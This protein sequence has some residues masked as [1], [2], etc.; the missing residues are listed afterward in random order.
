MYPSGISDKGKKLI[1]FYKGA[2][3]EGLTRTQAYFK[4]RALKLDTYA[5]TSM[6]RDMRVIWEAAEVAEPMKFTP[7]KYLVGEGHYKESSIKMTQRYATVMK[8]SYYDEDEEQ[9]ME[10]HITVRH[11]SLLPPDELKKDAQIAYEK[12]ESP[13]KEITIMP[14]AGYYWFKKR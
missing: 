3:S 5:K 6:L 9:T 1:S 8:I 2:F 10:Q 7:K 11:D 12:P 13:K 4:S 14:V